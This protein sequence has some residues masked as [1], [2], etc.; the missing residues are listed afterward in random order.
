MNG[1]RLENFEKYTEG[2]EKSI[3]PDLAS[4][5]PLPSLQKY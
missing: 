3:N 1:F 5:E 4:K 2:S